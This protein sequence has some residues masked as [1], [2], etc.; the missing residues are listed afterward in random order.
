MAETE[1]DGWEQ[2]R[3]MVRN[4][5]PGIYKVPEPDAGPPSPKAVEPKRERPSRPR[6]P[7]PPPPRTF[8]PYL[9]VAVIAVVLG[10][11]AFYAFYK[12]APTV[13]PRAE[14]PQQP[15]GADERPAVQSAEAS[16]DAVAARSDQPAA[17][18]GKVNQ[19]AG[20]PAALM[21]RRGQKGTNVRGDPS[22]SKPPIAK[23]NGGDKLEK[24]LDRDPWLKVRFSHAG[25]RMEGWVR[26]DL[27]E[28]E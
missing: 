5:P 6:P 8:K 13:E 27:T 4:A 1:D 3:E 23:L 15:T 19:A 28:A 11:I 18:A 22:T 25:K 9:V 12:D 26:K 24:L 2:A 7:P 20:Q 14:A 21:I 17:N 10:G 16:T